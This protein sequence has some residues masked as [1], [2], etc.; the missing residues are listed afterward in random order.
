MPITSTN[1]FS[2]ATIQQ[3]DI[4]CAAVRSDAKLDEEFASLFAWVRTA[5]KRSAV[6]VRLHSATASIT[7]RKLKSMF[8][9]LGC[10]VTMQMV[11]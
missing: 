6:H 2:L 11:F 10:T 5:P 3:I 4:D 7:G 1:T 8:Q 9:T